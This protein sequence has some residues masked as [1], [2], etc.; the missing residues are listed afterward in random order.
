M[1]ALFNN[2]PDGKARTLQVR[3]LL[4]ITSLGQAQGPKPEHRTRKRACWQDRR[5]NEVH[6]G[7]LDEGRAR[8]AAALL[9]DCAHVY[10]PDAGHGIKEAQPI[11]YGQVVNAFLE[12][13]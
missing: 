1:S 6:G 7:A 4:A 10:F 5:G 12:S 9:R 11:E 2:R 13:L 8:R 3:Q